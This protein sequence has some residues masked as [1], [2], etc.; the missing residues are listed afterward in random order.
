MG[1]KGKVY[2]EKQTA[3]ILQRAAR[4]QEQTGESVYAP[5]LTQEEILSIAAEAGIAPENV[6]S[7]IVSLEA[8][9]PASGFLNLSQEDERVV[10]AELDPADFDV[11]LDVA[12]PARLSHYSTQQVGRTLTFHTRY[13]GGLYR[14]E[15]TAK[16]G[17]TRI[18]V[19]S[20][21][22]YAYLLSLHPALLLA[23]FGSAIIAAQGVKVGAVLFA[24]VVL[25]LGCLAFATLIHRTKGKTAE[26]ADALEKRVRE[27]TDEEA[28]RLPESNPSPLVAEDPRLVH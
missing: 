27:T 4:M 21:L 26:L 20:L 13:K 22:L 7:A 9:P 6:E 28:T 18:R 1:E 2:S 16:N 23:L 5:G 12:K 3:E 19:T 25:M 8:R 15:V 10:N 17:R 11:I 14:V 24:F